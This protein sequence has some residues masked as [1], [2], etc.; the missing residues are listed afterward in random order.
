M[1]YWSVALAYLVDGASRIGVTYDPVHNDLFWA[2]RGAGAYRN[3]RPIRVSRLRRPEAAGDR[4][5]LHLQDG[6]RRLSALLDRGT[7]AGADHRRMGSTA[8]MMCHVADGRLDG[9]ATMYCN[10]WDVIGGL[11]L[12]Q[13]GGRRRQGFRRRARSSGRRRRTPARPACA[14]RSSRCT[15][16]RSPRPRRMMWP[17]R[18]GR[19]RS[20]ERPGTARRKW[21]GQFVRGPE[22]SS[23]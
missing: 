20:T 22:P 23:F 14:R 11:L 17:E 9:C 10:S 18:P 15:P 12:V 7:R 3:E 2:R 16:A 5:D 19:R 1:P 13:G 8:L 4:L 21:L 6:D